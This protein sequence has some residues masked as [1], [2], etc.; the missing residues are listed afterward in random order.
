MEATTLD[1][2]LVA[3]MLAFF[4][5]FGLVMLAVALRYG[6]KR[7]TWNQPAA[8]Y[9]RPGRFT[10]RGMYAGAIIHVV[11][12]IIVLIAVPGAGIGILLVLVATGCFYALCAHSFALASGIQ[13]RL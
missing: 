7:G 4:V 3:A 11:L 1:V 13:R 2:V 6:P 9:R 5:V 12:G 8:A 10:F